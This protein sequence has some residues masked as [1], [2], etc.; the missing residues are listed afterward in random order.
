MNAHWCAPTGRGCS[1]GRVNGIFSV[2][3]NDV[4]PGCAGLMAGLAR[5]ACGAVESNLDLVF[6][7]PAVP[8]LVLS[9]FGNAP[10]RGVDTGIRQ[11]GGSS[12]CRRG[13]DTDHAHLCDGELD[14]GDGFGECGV[15]GNQVFNGGILLNGHV[16]QIVKGRSH[17]LC[18]VE[19]G[20]L[21][22]TKRCV[23]SSHAIDTSQEPKM[24]L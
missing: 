20:G 6:V 18:L 15:G 4:C 14:V 2:A 21:I 1:G 16:C 24:D 11:G 17:L 10:V 8:N 12:W 9:R 7:C 19:F 5:Q 3:T 22:C 13:W 23:A